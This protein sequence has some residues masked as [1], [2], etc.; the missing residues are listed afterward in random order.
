MNKESYYYYYS[1]MGAEFSALLTPPMSHGHAAPLQR[2]FLPLRGP[3]IIENLQKVQSL[4]LRARL[5]RFAAR[6][7]RDEFPQIR[8]K[9]I[10]WTPY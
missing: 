9:F 1:P 2:K 7:P 6:T 10:P 5:A 3:S 4:G 8:Q